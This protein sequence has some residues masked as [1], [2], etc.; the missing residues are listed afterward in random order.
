MKADPAVT[1]A[2]PPNSYWHQMLDL[3]NNIKYFRPQPAR[4][5]QFCL[6]DAEPDSNLNKLKQS[7][8]AL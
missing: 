3:T 7:V 5:V 8:E 1:D 4:T 6:L 2:I